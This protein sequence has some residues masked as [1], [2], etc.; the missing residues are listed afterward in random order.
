M[1]IRS[2][3]LQDCTQRQQA[4]QYRS[5]IYHIQIGGSR[6]LVQSDVD[7]GHLPCAR[8]VTTLCTFL[9]QYDVAREHT[10][11]S[12]LQGFEHTHQYHMLNIYRGNLEC[13]SGLA[14][15]YKVS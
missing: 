12:V 5:S 7:S 15:Y 10:R 2:N 9:L 14:S 6:A 1:P 13:A 8:V 11:Q 3:L 4:L